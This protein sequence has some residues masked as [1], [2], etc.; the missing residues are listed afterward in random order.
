MR[1][2]K[3]LSIGCVLIVGA[4]ATNGCYVTGDVADDGSGG[5]PSGGSTGD[6]GSGGRLGTGGYI[7]IGGSPVGVPPYYGG[8][9]GA[10]A[11]NGGDESQ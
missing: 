3:T 5:V 7:G 2:K 1:T 11:P 10:G 4:T 9:N 6:V 8:T